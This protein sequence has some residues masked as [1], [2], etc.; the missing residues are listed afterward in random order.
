[1]KNF[2][3]TFLWLCVVIVVGCNDKTT[4]DYPFYSQSNLTILDQIN[5]PPS[6]SEYLRYERVPQDKMMEIATA[7]HKYL[8]TNFTYAWDEPGNDIWRPLTFNSMTGDC[9]DFALACYNLLLSQGWPKDNIMMVLGFNPDIGGHAAL[10]FELDGETYII[11]STEKKII[12]I[13]D[14]RFTW[15]RAMV[16]DLW[17]IVE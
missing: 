4:D 17:Y 10:A 7:T 11:C 3:L 15:N 2:A 16:N 14:S 9:E 5:P 6:Y 13:A 8:M 12:P 1:M